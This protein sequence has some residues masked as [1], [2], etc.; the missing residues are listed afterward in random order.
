MSELASMYVTL[1]PTARNIQPTIERQFAPAQGI[2]AAAGRDSGNRFAENFRSATSKVGHALGSTLKAGVTVATAAATAA[3]AVGVA[4]AAQME[5]SEISFTTMLGSGEKAKA[6]LGDLS[7]FAAK[8][9]FDLPGLQTS[10]SSLVSA[11]ID[12]SKVIPIMTSLGNAT[13]GMGTGAEGVQRATTALQQ[14]NAAG[15]ISGED[16]NQLRDAGIPVFDLLTAATGKTT[17]QIAEMA[18]KGKLGKKELEQL[19]TAL[20]SGKGLEKFNGL[21]EK[22]SASLTGMWS[23]AKDTFAV[24]MAEAVT[25]IIPLLKDGLGGATA[26][27]TDVILPKAKT[28]LGEVAGG[29]KAFGAAW[30]ANDG[31][32]TS[33]GFPGFME[34]LAF[35]VHQ[36]WDK[37][38]QAMNSF[39]AA[40]EYNDGEVT[41]SGFN[42][43]MEKA[44]YW[45]R[46]LFDA[47][48]RLDFSSF[49][50]F[51][52][53]LSSSGGEA[54][55]ALASI[56][57]SFQDLMPAIKEFSAQAPALATGGVKLLASG[58][59]FL[60]SHVDTIIQFM[61]LLVAGFV[62]WRVA[63]LAINA[64]Q[65]IAVPVQL[66]LNITRIAAARAE[67]QAAAA[68]RANTAATISQ[69]G[70]QNVG[71]LTRIRGAAA[72]VAHTVA[73]TASSVAARTAAAGQWLLNA[74]MSANPIG[75]IIGLIALLVGGLIWF[76]TQ[77][78]LGQQ[79]WKTVWGAI[80]GVIGWTWENGIKP[81]FEAL[82]NF[83]TKTVPK[84]FEDGIAF[85]KTIWGGLQEI[86]KAPIRFVVNTVINDG[87]IGAFNTVAGFLG[88]AKLPRLDLP[89][90]FANGGWTGPGSKYQPAGIV[91]ADEFVIPKDA[92]RKMERNHPGALSHIMRHGTMAGYADGGRVKPLKDLMVTQGYNRIHKGIDYAAGVGTP[93]FA[94]QDG[95]VSHA[96]PGARAPGVWGGNEVHISGNGIETWFAHLSR[97]GVALGQRV[98][99][100]QQIANSGNTGISSGPHLHFGVFNGGW[101]N[102]VDPTAYLG[103]AN[104]PS[105]AAGFNPITG[106]IDGLM[107]KFKE[108]F[109]QGGMLVD[110]VG[111]VGK[112]ILTGAA[113][114]IT[115]LFDGSTDQGRAAGATLY[116]GGGWLENTGGAQLVQHNKSKPDAVLT[117]AQWA[118]MTRIA[119]D[120]TSA[121]EGNLYLD[122]G[123]FLGKVRGVARQEADSRIAMADAGSQYSRTGR[124]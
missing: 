115:G 30:A 12:A 68:T 104:A 2:A 110:L 101:P 96:G 42:G 4:T 63:Q 11:G 27:L 91:H 13:S 97:I 112:K 45:A 111:G 62:A 77:T 32:I 48:G 33:S 59:G 70:A 114:F 34:R 51:L 31:D 53:S 1:I 22:Q 49:Q 72:T 81:I 93:V 3:G 16:L 24:G 124:R 17:A 88:A 21:M 116:D 90:G 10:A 39:R 121:F 100:G 7:K 92:R 15:K 36:A 37:G 55:P 9:P 103:G 29:I 74:A 123:E 47:V 99:A 71:M 6:F 66:A 105:G 58:L 5:Q 67:M 119:E 38:T 95:V 8:T 26:F 73:T 50:G 82:G 107:G 40:W 25:P 109:P 84:A 79:I 86:A 87:L 23:T 106:I 56:G 14:M 46:Q 85:I 60:A 61:P 43:F 18:D 76:F 57:S 108:A 35:I 44:G 89:P 41:S 75:I 98:R 80:T 94:T 102:D 117:N 83:I 65:V 28:G 64:A 118:T 122:S 120:S 113:D 19:M 78:E 54:G 69:T 20:E 52:S